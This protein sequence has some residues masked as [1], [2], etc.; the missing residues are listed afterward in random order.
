MPSTI[1]ATRDVYKH[2][3]SSNV[4]PLLHLLVRQIC[5]GQRICCLKFENLVLTRAGVK[6]FQHRAR[7]QAEGLVVPGVTSLLKILSWY[8]FK[9]AIF[10]RCVRNYVAH[11]AE[12]HAMLK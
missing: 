5:H 6:R 11:S 4:Q 8:G 2:A 7:Q 9:L 1:V 3:A 12:C 10:C